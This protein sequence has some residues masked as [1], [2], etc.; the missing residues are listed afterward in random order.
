[1]MV[2]I[3]NLIPVTTNLLEGKFPGVLLQVM[4]GGGDRQASQVRTASFPSSTINWDGGLVIRTG[5]SLR[6]ATY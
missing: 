5:T 2:D 6:K 4:V 3:V 1:M